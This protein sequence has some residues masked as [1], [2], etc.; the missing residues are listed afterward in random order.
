MRGIAFSIVKPNSPRRSQP[1]PAVAN[2]VVAAFYLKG[3]KMMQ[4]RIS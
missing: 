1:V 3:K 2:P 4:I